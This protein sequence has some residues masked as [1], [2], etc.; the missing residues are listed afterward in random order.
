MEYD[1]CMNLISYNASYDVSMES[2]LEVLQSIY[3]LEKKKIFDTFSFEMKTADTLKKRTASAKKRNRC[4]NRLAQ[5]WE[6]VREDIS[7]LY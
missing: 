7:D 3:D 6:N 4:L 5:V 1:E 2:T